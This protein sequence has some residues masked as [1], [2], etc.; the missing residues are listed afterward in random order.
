MANVVT[1][2]LN[3]NGSL[4]LA[5]DKIGVEDAE[6]WAEEGKVVFRV[7]ALRSRWA[8]NHVNSGTVVDDASVVVGTVKEAPGVAAAVPLL[9]KPT[10]EG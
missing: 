3:A 6:R 1:I 5:S 9:T 10:K 8:V 2:I 7:A 4:H